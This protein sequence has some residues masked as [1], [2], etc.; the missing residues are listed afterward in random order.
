MPNYFEENIKRYQEALKRG[1]LSFG[2]TQ[3]KQEEEPLWLQAWKGLLK[4][5]SYPS[6]S[7]VGGLTG[8]TGAWGNV[9][10]GDIPSAVETFKERFN[11]QMQIIDTIENVHDAFTA[12][13][14]T[15]AVLLDSL[16]LNPL[17]LIGDIWVDLGRS[18]GGLV[19]VLQRQQCGVGRPQSC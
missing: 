7:I 11:R 18:P 15:G 10:S 13:K 1:E 9:L 3:P 14:A 6:S 5:T 19:M 17:E 4:L 12:L 2:T 8:A 16:L